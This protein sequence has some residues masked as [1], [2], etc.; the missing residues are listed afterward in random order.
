MKTKK[1][2]HDKFLRDIKTVS[3]H[4]RVDMNLKH[5]S[6]PESKYDD[7]INSLEIQSLLKKGFY[8]QTSIS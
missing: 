1:E 6:V 2:E 8:L 3:K 4:F 5:I 7:A